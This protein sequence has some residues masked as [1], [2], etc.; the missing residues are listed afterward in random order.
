MKKIVG[1]RLVKYYHTSV[2]TRA[3]VV[4]Y[5]WDEKVNFDRKKIK[6]ALEKKFGVVFH[7]DRLDRGGRSVYYGDKSKNLY[8]VLSFFLY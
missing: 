3:N 4:D 5:V 1:Y 7:Y 2:L 6:A 8:Y